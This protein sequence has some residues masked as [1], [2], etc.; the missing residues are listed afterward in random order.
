[1][2][3]RTAIISLL[4][5]TTLSSAPEYINYDSFDHITTSE[6]VQIKCLADNIFHEARGE[7]SDGKLA[8]GLVTLNRVKAGVFGKDV[9]SVV[10]QPGQFSWVPLMWNQVKT[11]AYLLHPDFKE[12]HRL[13]EKI[14]ITPP[15]DI[16]KNGLYFH[17]RE[18]NPGWN[19]KKTVTIGNHT[20]YTKK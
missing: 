6:K 16:T 1:M 4:F 10:K 18:V 9:C 3:L 14:F 5:V 15:K 8:V 2:I 12:A 13:A 19:L 20:F 17:N 11:K 7:S